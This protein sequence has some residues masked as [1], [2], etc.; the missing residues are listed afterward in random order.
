MP[1]IWFAVGGLAKKFYPCSR[2]YFGGLLVCQDQEEGV[3]KHALEG[4]SAL[5][6]SAPASLV[7]HK[8]ERISLC[9]GK[10]FQG[11]SLCH[12]LPL[13]TFIFNLIPG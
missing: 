8:A 5:S 13:G 4:P 6:P 11:G 7:P 12:A 3:L 1:L 9:V 10:P 2:G